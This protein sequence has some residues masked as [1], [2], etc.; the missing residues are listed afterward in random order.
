MDIQPIENV[1]LYLNKPDIPK[2][3]NAC[4]YPLMH[5]MFLKSTINIISVSNC[6][7][8]VLSIMKPSKNKTNINM[9]MLY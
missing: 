2:I 4:L 7:S 3:Q 8:S 6:S 5:Q 1:F 9:E